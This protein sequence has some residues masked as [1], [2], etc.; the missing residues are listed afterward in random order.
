MKAAV[1]IVIALA[2]CGHKQPTGGGD[3][4]ASG[5]GSATGSGPGTGMGTGTGTASEAPLSKDEC[6]AMLGHILDLASAARKDPGETPEEHQK[7]RQR[8]ID[9]QTQPC[10]DSVPRAQYDCAMKATSAADLGRCGS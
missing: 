7:T 10:V 6:V 9:E 1:M 3:G 5:S 4:S 8:L 2:A